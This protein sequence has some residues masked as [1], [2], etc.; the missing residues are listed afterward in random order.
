MGKATAKALVEKL[1]PR[2]EKLKVGLSTDREAD[3]APLVMGVLDCIDGQFNTGPGHGNLLDLSRLG[4][5][6]IAPAAG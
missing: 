4:L 5:G 3:Y 6:T 2:V 1:I